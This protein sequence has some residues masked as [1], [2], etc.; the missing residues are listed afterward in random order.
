MPFSSSST[1]PLPLDPHS[2]SLLQA[3]ADRVAAVPSAELTLARRRALARE[4]NDLHIPLEGVLPVPR[5]DLRLPLP[6]R[7]LP[8]RL[9][10]PV[11]GGP[12][13]AARDVLLVFFHGGG[14]VQGDLETHDNACA[15][16][17]QQLGCTLLSVQYRKAPEHRFPAP[18]DDVAEAYAW[19]WQQRL[20]WGAARIAVC[21]DSAGGHLAAHAL[22]ATGGSVPT[23]A[24]LLFYPVA[25]M[26][27]GNASYLRQTSGPGLTDAAMRWYWEQF[28]GDTQRSDDAAAVLMR[29]RWQRPPPPTV[30][31]LAWHD[32]L[33]DEGAA[34]AR[35]L[36]AAGAE[37]VMQDAMDM[38]HG[39]LRHCR[40]NAS[41]GA[42]S[43][44]AA[45]ALLR[46]L[47][48]A[49]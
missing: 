45:G 11:E 6:G 41:A 32:P 47:A 1:T 33:H 24:A 4:A 21:G 9:Y 15:F 30:V 2:R 20:R 22:F 29:Q 16:L 8:A 7:D 10:R 37:V 46:L 39:F 13:S 38:A 26:D 49:G 44:A 23:S 25:D 34:Y 48:R 19:A 18:C 31:S 28:L 40:V 35:L 3:A 27:F 12:A 5:E 17:V 36:R 14:W 43:R 42:H